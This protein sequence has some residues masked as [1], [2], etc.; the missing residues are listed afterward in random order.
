MMIQL[1]KKKLLIICVLSTN[2][3]QYCTVLLTLISMRVF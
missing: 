3:H 2:Q 1:N